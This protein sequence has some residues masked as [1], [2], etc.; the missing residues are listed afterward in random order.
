[1]D[2]RSRARDWLRQ[3]ENELLWAQDS[4]KGKF[5]AQ[6]CFVSQQVAGKAIKAVALARGAGEIRS[7][8]VARIADELGINGDLAKMGKRLDIYYISTRY[9]DSFS[10]G[11]PF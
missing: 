7:H 11:A 1:M 8:S 3:A 2:M 6:T 9:P 10:E 5:W 4:T